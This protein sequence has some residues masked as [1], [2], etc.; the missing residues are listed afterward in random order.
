M[1]LSRHRNPFVHSQYFGQETHTEL[2]AWGKS[3]CNQD[4]FKYEPVL[5]GTQ[6]SQTLIWKLRDFYVFSVLP[7]P[8]KQICC[9]HT[10]VHACREWLIHAPALIAWRLRK[11]L[12]QQ[13]TIPSS[14]QYHLPLSDAF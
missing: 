13:S 2:H 14:G 4:D 12:E 5:P 1:N 8:T 3:S 6:A 11:V 10:H 9:S 7:K